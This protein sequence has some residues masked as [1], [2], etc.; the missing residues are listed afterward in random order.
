MRQ[1][2]GAAI[3]L[4][5]VGAR[6]ARSGAWLA[7]G[8]VLG[9]S[10]AACGPCGGV[11]SCRESPRI[12]VTGQIVD[13][14]SPSN[15]DRNAQSGA[16][17]PQTKGAPGVRVQVVPTAGA[18]VAGA[19]AAATTDGDGFWQVSLPA[20]SEGPVTADVTVTPPDGAGY[21]VRGVDLRA[22]STRGQGNGLGRWT[23]DLFLTTIGLVKDAATG[24]GIDGVALTAVRRGGVGY[25]STPNTQSP[26]VTYGGGLFFLDVRPLGDG[27]LVLDF[28]VQRPGLAATRIDSVTLAVQ[29]EWLPPTF[30]GNLVFRLDS[31][32]RR[33]LP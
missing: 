31:A 9:A 7:A 15:A 14:G 30:A 33:V 13:R 11:E 4:R 29:H 18:A 12:G 2:M 26:M 1:L 22:S 19:S 6:V 21:T 17:I 10:A 32:G 28:V 8:A 25:A 23:R 3:G 27:P 5:G 24:N 20:S 16:D